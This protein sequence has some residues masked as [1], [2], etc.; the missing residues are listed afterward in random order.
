MGPAPKTTAFS[1]ASMRARTTAR[2]AIDTGSISAA[3]AGS[4]SPTGKT[5]SAGTHSRS[6]SAPS[7][8]MPTR[9]ML[10]HTFRLPIRHG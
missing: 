8:W 7:R 2:T 1:P 3:T 9:R 4:W 6:C 5:W 10:E